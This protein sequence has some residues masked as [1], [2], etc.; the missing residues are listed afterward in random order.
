VLPDRC[1]DLYAVAER[2]IESPEIEVGG[3]DDVAVGIEHA[4]LHSR[5]LI[6][7]V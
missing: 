3:L 6:T 1:V 5:L 2:R 4:C 7:V